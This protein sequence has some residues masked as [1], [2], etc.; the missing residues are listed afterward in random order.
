MQ[1]AG[2]GERLKYGHYI[3]GVAVAPSSN[4]YLPTENPFSGEQ[5]LSPI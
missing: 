3:D 1:M 4:R 5:A 2:I